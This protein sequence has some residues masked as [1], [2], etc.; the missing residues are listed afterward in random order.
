M[1]GH[2][3]KTHSRIFIFQANSNQIADWKCVDNLKNNKKLQTI[4]LEH[5]TIAKDVQYRT[6]LKLSLTTLIKIDAT[7]CK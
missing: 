1:N 7:L 6:K 4:Y 2:T 3:N 5:N